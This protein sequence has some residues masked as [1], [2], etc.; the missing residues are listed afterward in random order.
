MP[1]TEG[2]ALP[3]RYDNVRA[4]L[5]KSR[6]CVACTKGPC[7]LEFNAGFCGAA[8][9]CGAAFNCC[10]DR[11]CPYRLPAGDATCRNGVSARTV[12]VKETADT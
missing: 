1:R 10:E 7:G 12:F 6:L 8:E 5:D 11:A 2:F 9:I 4:A 3:L